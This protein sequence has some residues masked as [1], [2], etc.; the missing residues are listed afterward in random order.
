MLRPV[1]NKGKIDV[2]K[3]ERLNSMALTPSSHILGLGSIMNEQSL[4]LKGGV[5]I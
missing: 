4:G 1:Q 5:L 3:A 2:F